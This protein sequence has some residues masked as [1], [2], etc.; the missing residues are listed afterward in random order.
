MLQCP[1][2]PGPIGVGAFYPG[3]EDVAE[4]VRP[5]DG[6]EVTARAGRKL[7]IAK[8]FAGIRHCGQVN[9]VEVGI[10]AD[11]GELRWCHDGGALL[12]A[13]PAVVV[14]PGRAGR[15]DIVEGTARLLIRSCPPCRASC[16]T[17]PPP[18]G[19]IK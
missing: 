19:Q 14:T 2:Q 12:P 8:G 18:V 3:E 4:T 17:R 6:E 7:C 11:D 16:A 15:Q 9:G 1:G 10:G 13:T 5:L